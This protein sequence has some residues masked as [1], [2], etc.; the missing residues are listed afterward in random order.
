MTDKHTE[1]FILLVHKSYCNIQYVELF[2]NCQNQ[3]IHVT[4]ITIYGKQIV[5]SLQQK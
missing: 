1:I 3:G 4:L 5:F 2:Y